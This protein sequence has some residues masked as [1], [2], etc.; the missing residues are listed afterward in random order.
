[1]S[2]LLQTSRDRSLGCGQHVA[3]VRQVGSAARAPTARPHVQELDARGVVVVVA[4]QLV[5]TEHL[6]RMPTDMDH[7]S[8]VWAQRNPPIPPAVAATAQHSTAARRG[9]H[10]VQGVQ[11]LAH[12]GEQPPLILQQRR[13]LACDLVLQSTLL[14]LQP[15]HSRS[16]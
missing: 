5:I 10:R 13:F 9:P 11:G 1:M 7:R 8:V 16:R 6:F 15:L 2:Q 3:L 4:S 14:G 12:G